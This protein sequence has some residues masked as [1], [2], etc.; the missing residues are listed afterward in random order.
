[1][2]VH[3]WRSITMT[4]TIP[5]SKL[6]CVR[7][8]CDTRTALRNQAGGV[9]LVLLQHNVVRINFSSAYGP[10]PKVLI[11]GSLFLSGDPFCELVSF[12]ATLAALLLVSRRGPAEHGRRISARN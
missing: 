11:S 3:R 6:I 2:F 4:P 1:M 12:G 9:W 7:S 8:V 5:R 10:S